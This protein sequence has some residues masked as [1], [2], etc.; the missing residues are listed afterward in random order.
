MASLIAV[1][2]NT[3]DVYLD[4][5]IEYPGGNALNVS[6]MAA[7]LGA[8]SAYLGR[9]GDDRQGQYLLDCLQQEGVDAS[10]CRMLAGNNGWACVDSIDGERVFLGS[11]PGVC[12]QLR[13][14]ADDLAY[15]GTFGLAHSSLYSGLQDQLAQVRQASGCLSFDFSDNWVEFDWQALIQHVD[16]AFFSA[17][18]HSS[19]Q[20]VELA[21]SLRAMGPAVVVIT[22][23]AQGAIAVDARGTHEQPAQPCTFVDSMGAGDGFIAAF[24]LAWQARQSLADCLSE[25]VGYA[26]QVCGWNGGFGHGQAV[27]AERVQ[28]LKRALNLQ[29]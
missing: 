6:V 23:G 5:N 18:E 3:M 26:G 17:A 10:R 2:D 11:D 20:A 19:K 7:R 15:I 28:Q 1:G 24:L 9:V 21:N 4:R 27:D 22:R 12:R 25:G 13:L 16:I 14:D 29:G 8:R